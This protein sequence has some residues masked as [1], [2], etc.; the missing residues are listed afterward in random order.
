MRTAVSILM[1]AVSV[2]QMAASVISDFF[3]SEPDSL[4]TV[5]DRTTRMDM[6]DYYRSGKKIDA[7]NRLDGKS[8]IEELTDSYMKIKLSESAEIEMKIEISG[9][10]DTLIVVSKT[11]FEPAPDSKVMIF[12]RSWNPLD[13]KKYI[14]LPEVGDF[15]TGVSG[16]YKNGLLS[17]VE[18]PLV[19]FVFDSNGNLVA[20]TEFSGV[21]IKENY[22]KLKPYLKDKI[23]YCWTGKKYKELK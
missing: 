22:D 3:I 2:C 18:Y 7:D 12:D 8:R 6:I 9:S 17:L 4:F 14:A 5:I 19:R 21:M 23:V 10:S 13:S 15:I 16:K 20:S 11:L 1:L